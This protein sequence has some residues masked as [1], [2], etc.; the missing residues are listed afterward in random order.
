MISVKPFLLTLI[1]I[2]FI[3]I[4]CYGQ[5]DNKLHSSNLTKVKTSKAALKNVKK[6]ENNSNLKFD[7]DMYLHAVSGYDPVAYFTDS[8][9]E[10]GTKDFTYNWM[11]AAWQF[12]NQEHLDLFK[13]DPLKYAPQFGG[14]SAYGVA[15]G[16]LFHVDGT[17]WTIENGKL[18]LEVNKKSQ[19][20][21][22]QDP[23]KFIKIAEKN[24]PK[25]SATIQ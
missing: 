6:D 14:F 25:L 5:T 15:N 24:W 11:G 22:R 9:A 18:Y 20:K 4:T 3:A 23:Q 10:K 19:E 7:K 13:K 8:K 12:V 17:L 2:G 1:T 21:F 16:A